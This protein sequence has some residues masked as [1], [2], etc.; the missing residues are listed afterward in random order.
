MTDELYHYGVKGMKWGV[1]RAKK[2]EARSTRKVERTLA[3]SGRL[4]GAA[5]Y[6]KNAAER[7][8]RV[9]MKNAKHNEQVANRY[10]SEG[11][12]VRASISRWAANASRES[13]AEIRKQARE[14]A[15]LYIEKSKAYKDKASKI[16]TKKNVSLGKSRVDEI[17]K[18]SS[19]EGYEAQRI[20]DETMTK[21]YGE[22][23]RHR[24]NY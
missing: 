12:K 6:T 22:D 10:A 11:K 16:A 18:S 14:D 19:R 17:L 20:V 1:R 21:Q 24:N 4:E 5:R 13:A 23:W 3:K 8:A 7:R 9:E 2:R 15:K